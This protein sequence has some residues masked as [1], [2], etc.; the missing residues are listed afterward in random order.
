MAKH[1]KRSNVGLIYEFLIKRIAEN[2]TLNN[3]EGI[4]ECK[5]LL[6]K[7]FH[8]G[9]EIHKEFR[10]INALVNESVGTGA[11]AVSILEEVKKAA[12]T[13]N[14]PRLIKEKFNLIN[15]INETLGGREFYDYEVRGYKMYA[16]AATMVKHWRDEKS[17]DIPT[18]I[19]YQNR[20][21][22]N[23]SRTIEN[24][25]LEETVDPKIDNLVV[26]IMTEK[27]NKKYNKILTDEQKMI[28]QE[29][30]YGN[31]FS[32]LTKRLNTIRESAVKLFDSYIEDMPSKSMKDDA[33]LAKQKINEQKTEQINDEIITRFLE[34]SK[35]KQS[36][37]EK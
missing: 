19:K 9:T 32:S 21:I 35:L 25:K 17:L 3:E 10:L 34:I 36:L 8:K 31:D 29:Y 27:M 11:Q 6:T 5:S 30:V 2:V 4:N 13:F 33:L 22:E 12:S 26:R 28:I 16:T 23:L 20:L 15:E 1:N 37:L 18:V 14:G 24:V 7:Y